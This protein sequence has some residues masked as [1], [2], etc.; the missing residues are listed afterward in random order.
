MS[1]YGET[2]I[3][4]C[5]YCD[6]RYSGIFKLKENENVFDGFDRWLKEHGRE[7]TNETIHSYLDS[8]ICWIKY[9]ADGQD[10]R[11]G[12]EEANRYLQGG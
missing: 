9:L 1:F 8:A 2:Y 11:F 12:R 3:D 10:S 7:V 5:E 4:Y 6:D